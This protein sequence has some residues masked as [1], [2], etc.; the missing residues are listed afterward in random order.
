MH[1]LVFH[2]S[3]VVPWSTTLRILA[4]FLF[5]QTNLMQ[6]RSIRIDQN[7]PPFLSKWTHHGHGC[8]RKRLHSEC[9]LWLN[10]CWL[11]IIMGVQWTMGD[12]LTL[13]RIFGRR[14]HKLRFIITSRI[15][16]RGTRSTHAFD[17]WQWGC[18]S[19][20]WWWCWH[21]WLLVKSERN[22]DRKCWRVSWIPLYPFG[23]SS[24]RCLPNR[25]GHPKYNAFATFETW[26]GSFPLFFFLFLYN[27]S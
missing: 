20:C 27:G 17:T 21:G 9:W 1:I 4:P 7:E 5:H 11:L 19:R 8:M 2:L 6:Q 3:I 16:R 23:G 24:E 26:H 15:A 22:Q 25:D 18:I 14:W 12:A 13:D 10:R